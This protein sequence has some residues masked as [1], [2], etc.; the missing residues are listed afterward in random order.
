MSRFYIAMAQ[1]VTEGP[2]PEVF[3]TKRDAVKYLSHPCFR[4]K[5]DWIDNETG[6][7]IEENQWER[8]I[9]TIEI[10][11]T[12]KDQMHAAKILMAKGMEYEN[13]LCGDPGG[14]IEYR[15]ENQ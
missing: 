5:E 13:S 11:T 4:N 9:Y 3:R 15:E 10:G 8:V 12:K 14:P 2:E 6:E 7:T 1:S